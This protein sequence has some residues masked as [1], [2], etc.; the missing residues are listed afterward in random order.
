MPAIMILPVKQKAIIRQKHIQGVEAIQQELEAEEKALV[1]R[2][3]YSKAQVQGKV[4]P[5]C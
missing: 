5:S 1:A 4:S 2:A 3:V